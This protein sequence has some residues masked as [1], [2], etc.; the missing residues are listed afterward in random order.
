MYYMGVTDV[1]KFL[2]KNKDVAK[3]GMTSL[4]ICSIITIFKA[5]P[6]LNVCSEIRPWGE[7][8]FN[9][10]ISIFAAFIFYI[11][12]VYIP[13]EYDLKNAEKALKNDFLYLARMIDLVSI[14][15]EE[16]VEI[17][18]GK[19]NIKWND[20]HGEQKI[21]FGATSD[22]KEVHDIAQCYSQKELTELDSIYRKKIQSIKQSSFSKYLDYDLIELLSELEKVHIIGAIHGLL[23]CEKYGIGHGEIDKILE[24]SRKISLRV[25]KKFNVEYS[26]H[27]KE[28]D[29]TEIAISANAKNPHVITNIDALNNEITIEYVWQQAINN[30]DIMNAVNGDK[31]QLYGLIRQAV[32]D[33]KK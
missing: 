20:P 29:A 11:F 19:V 3:L 8:V 2:K 23:F 25:Q 27:Q 32:L 18:D 5:S 16:F 9:I 22:N 4:L 30:P 15:I 1:R 31:S 14:G 24:E 6:I 12:Q 33:S 28:L 13:G 10:C 7:L 21:F 26:F 17:I